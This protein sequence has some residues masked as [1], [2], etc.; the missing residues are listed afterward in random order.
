VTKVVAFGAFVEILPGVEGLVHISE[1]ADHHVESPSEVV[2]PGASLNVKILEIDEERRRL[3]LSIKRVE[4]QN[5]PMQDLGAQIA[6]AEGGST[7]ADADEGAAEAEP[8]AEV[9]PVAEAPGQEE[10]ETAS[11]E[12]GGEAQEGESVS[13]RPDAPDDLDEAAGGEDAA[14]GDAADGEP[15]ESA[16]GEGEEGETPAPGPDA[17]AEA[18]PAAEASSDL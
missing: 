3:S 9:E 5:M 15:G 6:E 4:G 17:E 7:E 18:E 1:L 10:A 13:E 11:D 12:D 14:E 16:S 8:A 2:E